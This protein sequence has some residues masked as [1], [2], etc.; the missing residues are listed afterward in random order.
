MSG[1]YGEAIWETG[2]GAVEEG[3]DSEVQERE[4]FSAGVA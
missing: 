2:G 1:Y 4:A 3:S